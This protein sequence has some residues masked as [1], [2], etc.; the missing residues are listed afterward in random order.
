KWLREGEDSS[1]RAVDVL[2]EWE[3]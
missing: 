1:R 2:S 3:A